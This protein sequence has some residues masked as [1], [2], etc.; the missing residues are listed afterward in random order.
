MVYVTALLVA[1]INDLWIEKYMKGSR[2]GPFQSIIPD[3]PRE[4][5]ENCEKR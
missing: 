3:S 4:N 5:E 2:C 1:Q